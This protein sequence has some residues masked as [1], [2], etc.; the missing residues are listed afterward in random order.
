MGFDAS[1]D[2]SVRIAGNYCCAEF[3]TINGTK[4]EA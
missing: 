4:Y 2:I 3:R 1:A